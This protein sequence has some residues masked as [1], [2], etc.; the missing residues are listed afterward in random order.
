[1]TI[2]PT[3]WS[4]TVMLPLSQASRPERTKL[5]TTPAISGLFSLSFVCPWN[6]GSR[7]KTLST[8][9]MPSRMSSLVISSLPTLRSWVSM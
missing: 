5:S 7:T 4:A 3:I 2:R 1:M 9:T 6:I 8:P